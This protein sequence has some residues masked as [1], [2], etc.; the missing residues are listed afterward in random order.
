MKC[1]D[2]HL[3]NRL[4]VNREHPDLFAVIK[5]VLHRVLTTRWGSVNKHCTVPTFLKRYQDQLALLFPS[6]HMQDIIDAGDEWLHLC[7]LAVNALHG[8]GGLGSTIFSGKLKDLVESQVHKLFIKELDEAVDKAR[9]KNVVCGTD[10]MA[11]WRDLMMTRVEDEVQNLHLLPSKRHVAVPYRNAE[12]KQ[13]A[14][15]CLADH[16]DMLIVGKLKAAGIAAGFLPEM[17]CE[18]M[19]GFISTPACKAQKVKR[20]LFVKAVPEIF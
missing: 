19:L 9:K 16:C 12:V 11:Q 1:L 5:P 13:V 8:V 6:A 14:I 20:E 2:L 17:D 15:S 4:K 18:V 7:P 10:E 3:L